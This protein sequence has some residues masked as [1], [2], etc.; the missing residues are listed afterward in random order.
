MK[1]QPRYGMPTPKTRREFEHNVFLTIDEIRR[2]EDKPSLLGNRFQTLGDS[3]AR[4]RKLPNGRVELPTIDERLRCFSNMQEC[5]KYLPMDW[6]NK[7]ERRSINNSVE[8]GYDKL[9]HENT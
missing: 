3:L 5:L 2:C 1:K 6:L 8:T 4:A 7:N 9:L